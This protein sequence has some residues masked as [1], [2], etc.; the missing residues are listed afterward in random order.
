M[1]SVWGPD[2]Q[3]DMIALDYF[4]SPA[5]WVNARWTSKFFADTLPAFVAKGL[6]NEKGTVWLP[7]VQHV[8]DMLAA[9]H[10]DLSPYY[11]W[12][13]EANASANPLYSATE[14]ATEEL[15]LCP[16][17]LTNATQVKPLKEG[18]PFY[19]LRPLQEGEE[20][21]QKASGTPTGKRKEAVSSPAEGSRKRVK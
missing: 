19:A 1:Y 13:I 18:G 16:D 4:F 2:Q 11:T 10:D 5:G 7:H 20:R 9:H 8:T 14:G 6:L 3:Y 17:N 21:M 15:L 12:R